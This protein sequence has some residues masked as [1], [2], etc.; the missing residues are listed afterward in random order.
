MVESRVPQQALAWVREV[1]EREDQHVCHA[2][3]EEIA[4]GQIHGVE[5]N[6]RY[7]GDEL[8]ERRGGGQEDRSDP[9][10]AEAGRLGDSSASRA[11]AVPARTTTAPLARNASR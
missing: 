10:P 11:S 9:D 3:A 7:V 2:G 6:R 1:D 8:W 5:T 4:H